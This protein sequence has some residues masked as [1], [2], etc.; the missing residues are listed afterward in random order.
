MDANLAEV[1]TA[2]IITAHF[3]RNIG[4]LPLNYMTPDLHSSGLLCSV[5]SQLFTDVEAVYQ[6]DC[7]GSRSPRRMPGGV[8][9]DWLS[10]KAKNPVMSERG[11]KKRRGR[12]SQNASKQLPASAAE[13]KREKA[14]SKIRWKPEISCA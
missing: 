11:E 10:G 3:N 4:N 14:S 9:S 8:R 6:S 1:H 13:H 7:Q 12:L 5:Y 2:S